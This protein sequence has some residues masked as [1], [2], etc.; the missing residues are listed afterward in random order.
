MVTDLHVFVS[1]WINHN[2]GRLTGSLC[3]HECICLK[4]VN[5]FPLKILNL[6]FSRTGG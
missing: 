2:T 5:S 6:I 1:H 4:R 3:V